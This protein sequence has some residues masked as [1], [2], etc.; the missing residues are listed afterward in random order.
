MLLAQ[1]K[2]EEVWRN[3]E[4]WRRGK[5]KGRIEEGRLRGREG[6]ESRGGGSFRRWGG[7]RRG[8]GGRTEKNSVVSE[9][10]DGGK[11]E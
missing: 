7:S 9:G 6:R 11:R 3:K 1:R 8:R 5:H 2:T 4:G 10:G